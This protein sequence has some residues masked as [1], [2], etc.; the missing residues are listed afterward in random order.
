MNYSFSLADRPAASKIPATVRP[1]RRAQFI[2]SRQKLQI[3]DAPTSKRRAM[4]KHTRKSHHQ[5]L[6]K[7]PLFFA[8]R[9]Q[10]ATKTLHRR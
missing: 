7:A 6:K 9:K 1:R 10:L 8:S 2:E 3:L 4:Q 5:N